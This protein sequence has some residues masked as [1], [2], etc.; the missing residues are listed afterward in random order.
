MGYCI[1]EEKDVSDMDHANQAMVYMVKGLNDHLLLPVAYYFISS[2]N[3]AQRASMLEGVLKAV[4]ECGARISSITFDGLPANIT[5][6]QELGANMDPDSDDFNPFF[7]NPTDGNKIAV[8]IDACHNEK[9]VRNVI[10]GKK[11]IYDSKNRKIEWKYFEALEECSREEGFILV[12]KLCRKH[13]EWQRR[14]MKVD[15]A[16]QTLSNSVADSM[17]YLKNLGH[18]KFRESEATVDFTRY[19]NNLFDI[20]NSREA[21][22]KSHFKRVLCEKNKDEIFA[23]LDQVDEYI[24]GL[25]LRLESGRIRPI[26]KTRSKT[27]F[28]GYLI[29][30]RSLKYLYEE[31]VE[32]THIM[33]EIRTFWLSQDFV[34][35]F[36]CK[37]RSLHGFN[38]NPTV[39]QFISAYRKLLCNTN[40][41]ASKKANVSELIVMNLT[42]FSNILQITSRRP[43][44]R[45]TMPTDLLQYTAH[46]DEEIH[47]TVDQ[48]GRF[49][50]GNYISEQMTSSSIAYVASKIEKRILSANNFS[51]N[52][53]K[54]VFIENEK[55][56]DDLIISKNQHIPCTSTFRICKSSDEYLKII[57][58]QLCKSNF[59]FD[60]IYLTIFQQLDFENLFTNSDF[61][62]HSDHKFY[63]IKS[64]VNE[65]IK[66]KLSHMARGLTLTA[67]GLSFRSRLHKFVHFRGQ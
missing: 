53:C 65:Y 12:N 46:H 29:N 8:F 2:L 62:S 21:S 16:V 6:C 11:T 33:P 25:K 17:E 36:F 18:P 28:R 1:S 20:F 52:S 67:Q 61:E 41:L 31:F 48:F 40:I 35:L 32:T 5:M 30:I 66:V 56:E 23:Y 37:I 47:D 39:V 4:S 54:V 60:A 7:V 10:A 15:I 43:N 50:V 26:I 49:D 58:P 64:I 34:E 9:N 24:R 3:G 63:L 44:L 59:R 42:S 22:A 57:N 55:V 27:A 51:C 19:F 13:M 45:E 38:D 14:K